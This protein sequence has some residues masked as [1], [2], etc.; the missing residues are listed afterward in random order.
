MVWRRLYYQVSRFKS[1]PKGAGRTGTLPKAATFPWGPVQ[2]D[3]LA[4]KHNIELVEE[5]STDL[6]S[7]HWNTKWN[8][9]LLE[10]SAN[11]GYDN[12]KEPV[13]IR[14]VLVNEI[15][16][17]KFAELEF[18]IV[19]ENTDETKRI[20]GAL[21]FDESMNVKE[22]FLIDATWES[23]DGNDT[24]EKPLDFK[25]VEA[26]NHNTVKI[27]F[28]KIPKRHLLD[29]WRKVSIKLNLRVLTASSNGLATG[30]TIWLAS[31]NMYK[32]KRTDS[33]KQHTT[34]HEIGH[35]IDM[36]K[37]VKGQKTGMKE[38]DTKVPIVHKG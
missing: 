9:G 1:G 14:T 21:F 22:D 4:N 31:A 10:S 33:E 32:G 17:A 23:A 28:S 5:A 27:N 38:K 24:S 25:Y 36:V 29:V 3:F 6:I 11:D 26:V 20:E 16:D 30:N 37:E 2:D 8:M 34:I 13:T 18:P 7:R 35:F 12:A 15:S 19:K